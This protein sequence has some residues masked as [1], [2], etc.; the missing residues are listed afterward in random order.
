V[1][2]LP[3]QALVSDNR[4]LIPGR[5][6]RLIVSRRYRAAKAALRTIVLRQW[7]RPPITGAVAMHV[8]ILPPDRRRRDLLNGA[9]MLGDA[10]EGA[11]YNDD[12]QIV[13]A[14]WERLD[15][16]APMGDRAAAVVIIWPLPISR[17]T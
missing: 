14:I 17:T 13:A 6:G 3:Y 5:Q 15:A 9:K 2:I 12:R 7:R 1:L 8:L 4:R 11:C 10:L 16:C